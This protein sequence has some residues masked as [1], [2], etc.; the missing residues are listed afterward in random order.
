[1]TQ[2]AARSSKSA[3]RE[4]PHPALRATL[5][6]SR[7]RGLSRSFSSSRDP[8][9]RMR[10]EGA[11]KRRMRGL[12]PLLLQVEFVHEPMQKRREENAGR[13]DDDQAREERVKRREELAGRGVDRIDR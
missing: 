3:S 4:T 8:S 10:G 6:R 7:G 5:S 13:G 11:A 2:A 9:P 1:M 12:T